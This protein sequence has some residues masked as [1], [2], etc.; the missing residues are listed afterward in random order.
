MQFVDARIWP[1]SERGLALECRHYPRIFLV[2]IIEIRHSKNSFTSIWVCNNDDAE[3]TKYSCA[4]KL[5]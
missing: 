4:S 3:S 1:K 5:V 2:A